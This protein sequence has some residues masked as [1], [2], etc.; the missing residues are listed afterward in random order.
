M[1]LEEHSFDVSTDIFLT[2]VTFHDKEI[3]KR[4]HKHL[5]KYILNKI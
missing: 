1:S 4:K 3:E 2:D 5:Y